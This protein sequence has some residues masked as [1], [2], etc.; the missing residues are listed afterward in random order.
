MDFDEVRSFEPS[1]DE[2]E[3]DT[4]KEQAEPNEF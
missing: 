3:K 1:A 4:A 2:K